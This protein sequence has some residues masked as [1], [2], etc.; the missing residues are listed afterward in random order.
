MSARPWRCV[1]LESFDNLGIDRGDA[2]FATTVPVA[3]SASDGLVPV[4]SLHLGTGDDVSVQRA[5]SQARFKQVKS[6]LTT[7][8]MRATCWPAPLC[9]PEQRFVGDPGK[10]ILLEILGMMVYAAWKCGRGGRTAVY[11]GWWGWTKDSLGGGVPE[12]SRRRARGARHR[13]GPGVFPPLPPSDLDKPPCSDLENGVT[14]PI[15]KE[16]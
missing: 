1:W 11:S 10:D 8:Q 5:L 16:V 6:L 4:P 12:R 3:L 7:L 14:V 9:E 15:C 13:A 2:G